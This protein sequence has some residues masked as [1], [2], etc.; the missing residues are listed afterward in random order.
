MN[1]PFS[2]MLIGEDQSLGKFFKDYLQRHGYHAISEHPRCRIAERIGTEPPDLLI[3]DADT[4]PPEHLDFYRDLRAT[5]QGPVLVLSGG[6]TGR[7][8]DKL[9]HLMADAYLNKP[10]EPQTLLVKIRTLLKRCHGSRCAFGSLEKRETSVLH[11]GKLHINRPSRR[12]QYGG[13]AIHLSSTEFDLLTF[14]AGHAGQVL[15]RD[16]INRQLRGIPYDGLDRSIDVAVSR[17]RKKL[18]DATAT[19][20]RIKTVW[21]RGYLFVPDAWD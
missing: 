5:Y 12:V 19:P 21:G 6:E 11:F 20:C 2:L 8:E 1:Q 15:D 10:I 17:L 13:D 3:L 14:L 16:T 9:S 4:D 7:E 18:G